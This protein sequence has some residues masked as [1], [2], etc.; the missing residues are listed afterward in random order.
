[1][2]TPTEAATIRLLA[3]QAAQRAADLAARLHLGTKIGET[4]AQY[5]AGVKA[6]QAAEAGAQLELCAAAEAAGVPL[7]EATAE[8]GIAS[9]AGSAGGGVVVRVLGAIGRAI[10][11][12]GAGTAAIGGAVAV[13]AATA[14]VGGS[15]YMASNWGKPSV[16]P[17]KEGPA[18]SGTHNASTVATTPIAHV[19]QFD[20][21]FI[22]AVN[23]SGWS[24]IGRPSDVEN[25]AANS[26]QDGGTGKTPIE[27]KKLVDKPF[28]NSTAAKDYLKERVTPGKQ[29]VWTGKWLKFEG[30][31]YRTLHV[32]L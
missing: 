1:M 24:F 13:V 15:I 3:K 12:Q 32:G 17:V 11:I 16:E 26:F 21:Y 25:R 6:L 23:T 5:E 20:Q 28:D 19:G 31:D 4:A 9:G 27:F 7:A 22:Y 29:S 10:G 2:P 14:V 8:Y 30:T 18:M